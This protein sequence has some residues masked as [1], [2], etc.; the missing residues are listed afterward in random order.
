MLQTGKPARRLAAISLIR[1]AEI[2]SQ[3]W[4]FIEDDGV[5]NY[6]AG[7]IQSG[8]WANLAGKR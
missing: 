8:E 5:L 6:W 7:F 2:P 1:A 4:L 3:G